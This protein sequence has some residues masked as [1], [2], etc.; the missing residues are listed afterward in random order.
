MILK[1]GFQR[2]TFGPFWRT[3]FGS[4]WKNP[5][6]IRYTGALI[7]L[8]LHFGPFSRY[9]ASRIRAALDAETRKA[10]ADRKATLAASG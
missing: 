4:L 7:A 10:A 2:A 8:Y 1:L 5:R 9:V 3:V 6:S